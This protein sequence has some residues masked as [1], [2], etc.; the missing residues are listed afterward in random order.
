MKKIYE[1]FPSSTKLEKFSKICS[2][3]QLKMLCIK[4]DSML[5][6]HD[7][8]QIIF[9]NPAENEKVLNYQISVVFPRENV[10][11]NL[12]GLMETIRSSVRLSEV[13][14]ARARTGYRDVTAPSRWTWS[15][16]IT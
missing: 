8:Y 5:M 1:K 11:H 3:L 12:V 10:I 13:L 14:C 6:E 16:D 2:P 9:R 15:R 7:P 4:N